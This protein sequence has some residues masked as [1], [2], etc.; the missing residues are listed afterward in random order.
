VPKLPSLAFVLDDVRVDYMQQIQD[1]NNRKAFE[2]LRAH[3][4]VSREE[5]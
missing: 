1:S 4:L 2:A 3:Y 5:D